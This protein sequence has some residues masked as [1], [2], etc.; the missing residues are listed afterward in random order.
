[1][2]LKGTKKD[3]EEGVITSIESVD[4]SDFHD[5]K[6]GPMCCRRGCFK[7]VPHLC[8]NKYFTAYVFLSHFLLLLTHTRTHVNSK[9]VV[10]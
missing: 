2:E 6:C 5:I 4:E 8:E 7:F 3:V 9:Q 10:S 1:M